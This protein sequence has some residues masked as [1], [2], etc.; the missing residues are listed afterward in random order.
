MHRL[1]NSFKHGPPPRCQKSGVYDSCSRPCFPFLMA[2]PLHSEKSLAMSPLNDKQLL[3]RD[4][5]SR[6]LI[7][8]QVRLQHF[9]GYP[10]E[11]L[12]QGNILELVNREHLQKYYVGI[13][14]VFD[15][16]GCVIRNIPDIVGVKI[17][18]AG[19]VDGEEYSHAA[20]TGDPVLPLGSRRVPV[21]LA[22]VPGL[23]NDQCR[24]KLRE[25]TMRTSPAS[26]DFVGSIALRRKVYCCLA[27]TC[28][29]P[30]STLS[31]SSELGRL[32]GKMYS[33]APGVF[34]KTL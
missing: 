14:R 27:A 32:P 11:P 19:I 26:L 20:L 17:H 15:V 16:V 10:P 30:I 5:C 9:A 1:Q 3:R 28:W 23:E 21:Q 33:G 2:Y 22:D 18:G 6:L 13:P 29:P 8:V 31:C 7:N 24:G 12:V 34:A 4:L 25:S